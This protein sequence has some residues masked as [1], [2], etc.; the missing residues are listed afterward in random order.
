MKIRTR[1]K[2]AGVLT[3]LIL[4]VYGA[5]ILHLDRTMTH[6]A[7]EVGEA[8]E[9]VNKITILR[10]LTM[11]YLLYRTERA[12]RQWSTVYAEV[13]EML[14]NQEN[15]V[16]QR[17]HGIGDVSTKLKIV[18]DTFSRL[19]TIQQTAAADNPEGEARGELQNRL[20]T[21]LLLATQDL[22]TRFFSLTETVNGKLVTTQRLF[23]SLDILAL[24]VLGI[25][26]ISN[27]VFLQRSVVRPV[28]KLHAGAE[29]IGAGNLDYQVGTTS[30]DEIGELSQAF[31]RMTAN[32]QKVTVSRDDLLREM[33]ERRRTEAALQESREDL[34]RA[35]AVA[36][37]GSWRLNVQKNE[38]TWSAENHRIFGIPPGT[39]MA[40]ETFLGTIHPGD[41][42]YVDQKWRAALKGEPYDI[43]H[44]LI[45]DGEVK[46]VRE[47]AGLEFDQEGQL[48]GG[49]GTTQDIT[50]RKRAG[51]ALEEYSAELSRAVADL[52]G[53]N[54][55][56]ERFTY[57]ISHDLKS[58]LVT[59]STFLGY[60]E[61]DLRRGDADRVGKDMQYM[62]TAADKMGQLL[63]ELLEM[64]RLGRMVNPPV[65]VSFQE[66]VQEVLNAMAGPIAARGVE[67]QVSERD[68]TLFGDRPRLVEIWQNVVENAVKYMG[69]QA[70]PRLT[71][72]LEQQEDGTVFFVCDN[73]IGIEPRYQGKIFGIFEKLD[74]KS[75]GTGIGLAVVKRIVELYKGNIW[76][77]S[78]GQDRG[79]CFR[80]TLPEA[81]KGS[82]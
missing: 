34:N 44:R 40:Y 10:N 29:I 58:P 36:Q 64:S 39:P 73:G 59:I 70:R 62:R 8:N 32:L 12:K 24:L 1:V 21:Q 26:L 25:L 16:L 53:K 27:A 31:D 81:V 23:S 71:I 79:S 4:L 19:M 20:T 68:V 35:Q 49:F 14:D 2:I 57:M 76:V 41:R 43:E 67:V 54:A 50:E 61:E 3:V 7:Q 11:D 9:F 5:V 30:Q 78:A 22:L 66:L 17:E 52:E 82:E 47:Q 65:E 13:L 77:E 33:A 45:V 18:G 28:L 72:G 51:E 55:E 69:E 48:L 56:M 42:E 75:G 6:L 37:V 74:S 15:L 46:W 38:L 60:L 80:F 63:G